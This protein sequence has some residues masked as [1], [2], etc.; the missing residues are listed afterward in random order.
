MNLYFACSLTGGRRDEGIYGVIVRHLEGLGHKVPT[1]HLAKP[2]VMELEKVTAAD[3]IYARDIRW[4]EGCEA[5]IAE[6]STPSHGVGYEI[7]YAL[8]LRKPVLCCYRE[9][10]T[11][12]KMILGNDSPG[13]TV[14]N[15]R[16]ENEL[17][18]LVDEFL[19]S[20]A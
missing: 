9:G 20:L 5:L 15:Y 6:V 13:L 2:G 17:P 4:I 19:A 10:V 3:E 7:G 8:R 11:V 14:R 18:E 16:N 12:S 1:A